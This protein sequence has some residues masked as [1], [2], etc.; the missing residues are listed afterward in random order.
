MKIA[1]AEA[2]P[3][4]AAAASSALA[5][6]LAAWAARVNRRLPELI[7]PSDQR[8]EPVHQ[9]MQYAL[10]GGYYYSPSY[11]GSAP[12]QTTTDSGNGGAD[13]FSQVPDAGTPP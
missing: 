8:P 4:S 11:S 9:A 12:S 6:P 10:T 2:P 5:G 3:A 13:G 7:P 1:G